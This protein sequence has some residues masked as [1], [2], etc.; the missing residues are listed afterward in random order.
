MANRSDRGPPSLY[1]FLGQ[2]PVKE[3]RRGSADSIR[4]CRNMSCSKAGYKTAAYLFTKSQNYLANG[5]RPYKIY[6]REKSSNRTSYCFVFFKQLV[7]GERKYT[8]AGSQC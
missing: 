4:A 2:Q 1:K 8:R 5:R 3:M 7:P 6:A